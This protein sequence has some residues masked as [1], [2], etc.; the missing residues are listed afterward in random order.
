VETVLAE[1][2][3]VV[4]TAVTVVAETMVTATVAN[5][6][7][8]AEATIVARDINLISLRKV[9]ENEVASGSLVFLIENGELKI[10]NYA[11][12]LINSQFSMTLSQ[13]LICL[14]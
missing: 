13:Q 12:P 8:V 4:V 1:L 10:E 5:V 11:T 7:V 3:Q 2:H 9:F 14:F 6:V